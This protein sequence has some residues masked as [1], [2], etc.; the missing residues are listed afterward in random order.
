MTV[1]PGRGGL[2]EVGGGGRCDLAMHPES[3]PICNPRSESA[4]SLIREG[5]GADYQD[6]RL[7]GVRP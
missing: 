6:S 7:G 4:Y 2:T 3:N 1:N 5:V